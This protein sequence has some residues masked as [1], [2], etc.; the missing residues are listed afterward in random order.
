MKMDYYPERMR[1][2]VVL[3]KLV[4]SLLYTLV[5]VK[6]GAK[7]FG[8]IHTKVRYFLYIVHC[9]RSPNEIQEVAEGQALKI[10]ITSF[11]FVEKKLA[12]KWILAMIQEAQF[13]I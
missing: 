3:C 5:R 9:V 2:K 10:S 8:L 4:S 6:V 11:S 13:F 12:K 1:N 7:I